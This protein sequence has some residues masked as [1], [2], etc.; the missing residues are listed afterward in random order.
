[1]TLTFLASFLLTSYLLLLSRG[2]PQSMPSSQLLF[3]HTLGIQKIVD[4]FMET[5]SH[6]ITQ[7]SMELSVFL[8]QL[9]KC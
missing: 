5:G 1:M 6:Y 4:Q 8:P 9:P 7:A 2:T 3:W